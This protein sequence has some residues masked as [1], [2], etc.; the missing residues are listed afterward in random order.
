MNILITGASGFIGTHFVDKTNGYNIVAVSLQTRLVED[1]NFEGVDSIVHFAGLAHQM[2]GAPAEAYFK[3]NSDL[4]FSFAKIAK[5]RGVKH[6]IF[7][8]TAKVY[9]ESSN[10]GNPFNEL[11]ACNPQDPYS[12]SKLQAEE[13]LKTLQDDSFIVSIIRIPLVY[14]AGV[15]GN[16]HSLMRLVQKTP[17]IPLGGITNKRSLVY[18]GNLVNLIISVIEKKQSG[19][20]VACDNR[21]LSTSEL[22]LQIAVAFSRKTIIFKM[23]ILVKKVLEKVKPAIIERLY[24]SFE[25]DATCTNEKL[26]YSPKYTVEQGI[27]EMVNAFIKK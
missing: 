13:R 23:P 9:G 14:G 2:N 17:L 7:I 19:I 5:E 24:G 12:Q 10:F 8:S 16:L 27:Q 26:S 20:F 15:K 3:I 21:S 25:L 11:S 4:T 22:L 1:V 18:V 6:F